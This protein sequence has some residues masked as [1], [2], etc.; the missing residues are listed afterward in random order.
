MGAVGFEGDDVGGWENEGDDV[1]ATD[2][3]DEL[4]MVGPER[5]EDGVA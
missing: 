2:G 3:G 1:G 4:G 5:L